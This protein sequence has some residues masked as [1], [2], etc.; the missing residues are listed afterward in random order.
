[1]NI[2]YVAQDTDWSPAL[3]GKVEDKIGAPLARFL[4]TSDFELSMHLRPDR[5]SGSPALQQYEMWAVLQTFDGYGNEIV[6]RRGQELQSLISE[7]SNGLGHVL[8]KR[9][10]PRR[11][12][13]KPLAVANF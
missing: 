4:K 9:R 10:N 3:R 13:L 7:I 2:R 8:R 11:S 5:R 1:M 12:W 6:R